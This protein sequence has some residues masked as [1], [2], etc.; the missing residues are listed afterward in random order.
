ML[1]L[2]IGSVLAVG[3]VLFDGGPGAQFQIGGNDGII[4]PG[5]LVLVV[6]VGFWVAFLMWAGAQERR[7]QE[8][9]PS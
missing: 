9:T 7:R 4:V 1:W 8:H 3:K 2:L 6:V 5:W